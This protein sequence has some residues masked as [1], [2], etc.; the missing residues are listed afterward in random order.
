MFSRV[1]KVDRH[2]APRLVTRLFRGRVVGD[3]VGAAL[4]RVKT[5]NICS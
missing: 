5:R 4:C 2:T 1:V 3:K